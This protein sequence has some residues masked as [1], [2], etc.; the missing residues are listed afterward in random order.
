MKKYFNFIYKFNLFYIILA[1]IFFMSISCKI[2][3]SYLSSNNVYIYFN[4][5]VN[6]Q[7]QQYLLWIVII[8]LG[9]FL[10]ITLKI[11]VQKIIITIFC[12]I[13]ILASFTF[14]GGFWEA[15]KSYFEFK[16]PYNNTIIIEE[17][18]WLLGGWSNVYQK[19]SSNII[20]GLNGNISTDDGYRPFSN[21]D[22]NIEWSINS[23][24]ITYG[25]GSENIHK[26]EIIDL[27]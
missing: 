5:I 6:D 12:I 8:V 15:D 18:S 2:A 9:I 4:R 22:Y 21:N 1:F 10:I 27:K 23:V 16:S 25:F 7:I 17:C 13:F 26:S 14:S 19:E 3:L 20:C 11:K 24:K